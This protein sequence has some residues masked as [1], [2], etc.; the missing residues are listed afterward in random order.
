MVDL[1]YLY[2]FVLYKKNYITFFI[3]VNLLFILCITIFVLYLVMLNVIVYILVF[4]YTSCLF[5][6]CV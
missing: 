3:F 2:I 1:F 5:L 6:N 4:A